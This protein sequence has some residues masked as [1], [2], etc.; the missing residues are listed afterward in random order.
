[1]TGAPSI[2]FIPRTELDTSRWNICIEN[3]T[4]GLVYAYSYYLDI[5]A[6]N[7]DALVLENKDTKGYEAVMPLTWNK[8]FGI[9]YLH[10][11]FLAAQLGISQHNSNTSISA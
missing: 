4:N 1:M 6:P 9:S 10:Q 3:A 5:M 2:R 7:W 8:K 11:P